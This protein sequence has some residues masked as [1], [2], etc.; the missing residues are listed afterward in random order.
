M[1][2]P[3]EKDEFL[4][5]NV[6]IFHNINVNLSLVFWFGLVY[7]LINGTFSDISVIHVQNVYVMAH[8]CTAVDVYAD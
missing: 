8:T 2:V 6:K 1:V 3:L 4:K 5:Q 7:L